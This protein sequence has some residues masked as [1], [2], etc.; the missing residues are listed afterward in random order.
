LHAPESITHLSGVDPKRI[1]KAAVARKYL[2]DILDERD[3]AGAFGWTLCNYPTEE[4]ARHAGLSLREYADQIIRACFL[5]RASPVSQ[6][7]NVFKNATSIKK[8]LNSMKVNFYHIESANTDLKI[9]T[10]GKK[11]IGSVFPAITFRALKYFYHR[12]GEEPA[13]YTLQ[14]SPRFEAEIMWKA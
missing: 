5:N 2:R 13:E 6:W 12:T 9:T 10:R 14:I 1:G 11:K 4:Q 3:Q 8:W 7:Q